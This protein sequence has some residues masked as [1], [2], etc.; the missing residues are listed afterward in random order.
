MIFKM[1][2]LKAY[3]SINWKCL[4][5]IV[6]CMNLGERWCR[7]IE[8]ILVTSK[9]SI[10]VN[11]SPSQEF[12]PRRGIRQGD[13]LAPYLFLLIGEV[14]NRLLEKAQDLDIIRGFKPKFADE[15]IN[16]IQYA[17]DVIFFSWNNP[18]YLY[19]L[20][21]VLL[22]FQVI[23]GLAINFNKSCMYHATN[24][25][26]KIREGSTILNCQ[27]GTV[28]F[29]YLGSLVGMKENSMVHWKIYWKNSM[30][31]LE[32]GILLL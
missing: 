7:W 5:H 9:I 30:K 27:T 12:S 15:Y 24:N 13:P 14:L 2:F 8:Q 26:D 23:T 28:H 4:V 1:D 16:I 31:E 18:Q 25:L 22:L 21:K 32:A 29:L 3:D 17:D 6:R 20:K 19:G 10:L 11:G